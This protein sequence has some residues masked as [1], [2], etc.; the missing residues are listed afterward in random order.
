MKIT[1]EGVST[2]ETRYNSIYK[3]CLAAAKKQFVRDHP[4]YYQ[5]CSIETATGLSFAKALREFDAHGYAS[6]ELISYATDY[7]DRLKAYV[8]DCAAVG[9]KVASCD[10]IFASFRKS[11]FERLVAERLALVFPDVLK[12][13]SDYCYPKS[14]ENKVK[15]QARFYEEH[16]DELTEYRMR[17]AIYEAMRESLEY[18]AQNKLEMDVFRRAYCSRVDKEII[19]PDSIKARVYYQSDIDPLVV[20]ARRTSKDSFSLGTDAIERAAS[21]VGRDKMLIKDEI[22]S[23]LDNGAGVRA[24]LATVK[25]YDSKSLLELIITQRMD[26]DTSSL[27]GCFHYWSNAFRF[28]K[29]INSLLIKMSDHY[30]SPDSIKREAKAIV[31]DE[32]PE[33]NDRVSFFSKLFRRK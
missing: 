7:I 19:L 3:S 26:Y 11:E 6:S 33:E 12:R 22:R 5:L 31:C 16:E 25:E 30:D 10:P 32:K 23:L 1:I 15:E 28:F 4:E 2:A 9:K 20:E 27:L 24:I 14:V 8:A 29:D 17:I 13:L 21:A 18:S